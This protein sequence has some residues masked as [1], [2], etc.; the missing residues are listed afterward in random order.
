MY[1]YKYG[2]C[3][4]EQCEK[5]HLPKHVAEEF[6]WIGKLLTLRRKAFDAVLVVLDTQLL[7]AQYLLETNVYIPENSFQQKSAFELGRLAKSL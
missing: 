3:S 4:R 2:L 7:V 6:L 5:Q 1:T